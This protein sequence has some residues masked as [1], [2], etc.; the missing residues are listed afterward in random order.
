MGGAERAFS[1][2]HIS[3]KRLGASL[4]A[5]EMR[6]K[7]R[8]GSQ[9][10]TVARGSKAFQIRDEAGYPECDGLQPE[11]SNA[12]DDPVAAAIRARIAAAEAA[13]ANDSSSSDASSGAS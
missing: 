4:R 10:V 5:E 2:R 13:H 1:N 9:D 11:R 3:D 8:R 7:L 6:Q 12:S